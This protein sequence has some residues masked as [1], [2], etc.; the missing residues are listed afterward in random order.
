MGTL[1]KPRRPYVLLVGAVQQEQFELF[2]HQHFNGASHRLP[3]V[4]LTPRSPDDF[5]L[6]E[7]LGLAQ[8]SRVAVVQGDVLDFSAL[9]KHA[10]AI[11]FRCA[12]AVFV[13]SNIRSPHQAHED[14]G[15]TARL[16][17]LTKRVQPHM[18]HAQ[19]KLWNDVSV[20]RARAAR[21]QGSD[22]AA[23]VVSAAAALRPAPP[24]LLMIRPPE[25]Q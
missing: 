24:G 12:Q 5:G 14:H 4:V 1:P 16:L 2:L 3:V 18:I 8:R 20:A 19:Y 10:S 17:G 25:P 23:W 15:T 11:D 13:F 22:P 9:N 7:T 6:P 21:H